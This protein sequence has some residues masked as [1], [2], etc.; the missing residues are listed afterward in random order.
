MSA[1]HNALGEKEFAFTKDDFKAIQQRMLL[2]AGI[3][4]GEQ[5]MQ[6]VYS[7]LARRLRKLNLRSFSQYLQRLE[8]GDAAETVEFINALTTNKT[9]FFREMHHFDYMRANLIPEWRN[10]RGIRPIRIWSSACSTG[11]EPYSIGSLLLAEGLSSE[12]FNIKILATD[13]DS[14]VLATA[15][16]GIYPVDAAQQIP[17]QPLRSGF[18]KG[19]GAHSGYMRASADLRE[20]IAFR[21]LNLNSTW[22]FQDKFDLIFCR[23]VM[24]YFDPSTQHRLLKRF[25]HHLHPGGILMLGHSETLGEMRTQF[26]AIGRTIYRKVS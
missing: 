13:L 25:W 15:M 1:E 19:K 21:Q 20:L 22:P 2:L 5:K 3:T 7:R 6:M 23:N 9:S 11:E 12:L 8:Q 17:P 16:A 10:H 4:L 24:I 18:L 14:R 26:E